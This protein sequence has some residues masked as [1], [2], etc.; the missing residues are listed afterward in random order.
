MMLALEILDCRSVGSSSVS[1]TRDTPGNTCLLMA[2]YST[3]LVI[4]FPSSS[5]PSKPGIDHK[6][7]AHHE[8]ESS[9]VVFVGM[10]SIAEIGWPM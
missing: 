1:S 5:L 10:P 6:T 7:Q 2:R 9:I 4:V 8:P 3:N